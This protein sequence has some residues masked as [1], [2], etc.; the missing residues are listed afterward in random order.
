MKRIK[1]MAL[2]MKG[3]ATLAVVGVALT[4]AAVRPV[5]AASATKT[6]SPVQGVMLDV[7][8]KHT[9]SYFAAVGGKCNLTL[10]VG[11]RYAGEGDYP[12][13][14]AR[15]QVAIDAGKKARIETASG[16]SLEF[17]CAKA[18]KSM[19]VRTLDVVAYSAPRKS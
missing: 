7:G 13:V 18:A 4:G 14:G 2:A 1:T 5:D 3:V 16:K 6:V 11:E 17:S 19:S 12:S 9:V 15:F 10:V 8:S